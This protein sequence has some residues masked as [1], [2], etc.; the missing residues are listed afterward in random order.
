MNIF[1]GGVWI[2]ENPQFTMRK[3]VTSTLD[4]LVFC[5]VLGAILTHSKVINKQVVYAML[6]KVIRMS[7]QDL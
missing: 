4:Y 1:F 3:W 2:A 5:P 6:G 7:P